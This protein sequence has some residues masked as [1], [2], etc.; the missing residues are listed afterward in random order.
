MLGIKKK[1]DDVDH[2][3]N[4]FMIGNYDRKKPGQSVAFKHAIPNAQLGRRDLITYDNNNNSKK[5]RQ[6]LLA[7]Q[8]TPALISTK[9][10]GRGR[11]REREGEGEREGGGG[12]DTGVS[13]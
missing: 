5:M 13:Y 3:N 6:S 12:A 8:T 7:N 4:N 2:M 9:A 11:G 1:E 10:E